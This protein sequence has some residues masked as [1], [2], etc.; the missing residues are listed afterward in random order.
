MREALSFFGLCVVGALFLSCAADTKGSASSAADATEEEEDEDADATE[1]PRD[2]FVAQRAFPGT[3]IDPVRRYE[4][5]EIA[6]AMMERDR[7]PRADSWSFVGPDNVGGRI[8]DIQSSPARPER[9]YVAA[10]AG[11]IFRSDDRGRTIRPIFDAQAT[12]SIGAI[13]VDPHDADT[14][15]VGTGEANSSGDSYAGTGM[16]LS[17]DGGST[18]RRMGLERSEHIG[19]IVVDPSDSRTVYVAVMGSMRIENDDRGV[20]R[21]RDMGETWERVLFTGRRV[22]AIDVAIDPQNPPNVYAGLWERMRDDVSFKKG[23]PGS[24]IY[25]S[26]DGGGTWTRSLSGLP[27]PSATS[28]RVG[29]SLCASS[30]RTLYSIFD[31]TDRNFNGVYRS[32]DGAATWR[33]VDGPS[34]G[35]I[36]SSYGWWFGNIRVNPTNANEVY[37]LGLYPSRSTDG[38]RTWSRFGRMH[39]DHHALLIDPTN[40]SFVYSGN[41]GGFHVSSDRGETFGAPVKMPIT[42]FYNIAIDPADSAKIFGGAQDNGTNRTLTGGSSDWGRIFGGDGFQVIVDPVDPNTIYAESQNGGL[43][44]S[45]DGGRTFSSIAPSPERTNWNTPIRLDPADH[46]A[47]FFGGNRLFRSSNAGT[48]WNAISPDLTNGPTPARPGAGTIT[49]F[50][51]SPGDS[52]TIY[53]GTDDGNVWVTRNG[54]QEWTKINRTLPHLYVTSVQADKERAN[55]VWVTF[56]GF[57]DE[58]LGRVFRSDDAGATWSPIGASLPPVPVNALLRSPRRA[59]ILYVGT[60]VGVFMTEDAGVSWR[61]LGAGMPLAPVVDIIFDHRQGR[62]LAATHGRSIYAVSLTP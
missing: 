16:Y 27:A 11:G 34:I 48:T 29:L 30:P 5:F 7:D 3:S 61:S 1:V 62:L 55:R 56:S 20:Y 40:P 44:R 39:A 43:G 59:D 31:D 2:W 49:T 60:D 22:G 38:G 57:D 42:Q 41:D 24:G 54:G 35:A 53:V 37:A 32:D 58:P 21:T 25:R 4:A 10:A 46:N 8:T 51:I 45:R 15:W 52:R 33:R 23:G 6:R 19:R 36:F 13:A 17:R 14:V 26:T 18:W 9:V 12:L 47:L 28:G 50:S